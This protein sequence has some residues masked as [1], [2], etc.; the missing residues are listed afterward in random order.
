MKKDRIRKLNKAQAQEG[1]VLYWMDRDRRA[2]HNWALVAAINTAKE[3]EAPLH[4]LYVIPD[5]F[6]NANTRTYDFMLKGLHE[7]AQTLVD[8]NI[9]FHLILGEPAQEIPKF[10]KDNEITT[11]FTDFTPLRLPRKWRDE[12]SKSLQIP[13]YEVD[14]RNIIPCWVTSE[15]EEYAARTIRPKIHKKMD[16]YLD[17]F[18]NLM[19]Y[20]H[21]QKVSKKVFDPEEIIQKL[22]LKQIPK[23]KYYV[24]GESAAKRILHKFLED[25]VKNYDDLRNDPNQDVLSDLSPYL[26]YGQISSQYIVVK[27]REY[28]AMKP[29]Y[30]ESI[31]SFLEELVVR[32][33][34]T[35]NYCY[36][37]PNYDNFAGFKD[38][39]KKTLNEHRADKRDYLYSYEQFEKAETH[40]DLWNAAQIQM[41][42]EGKM[43]GYMRMYW[44][45]KILEWTKSPEEA[46]EIAIKLN[47]TYE[48][49][50]RDPNGY[51]GIAWSIGGIH[52]RAWTEREVYG[53]IRYM[54]YNGAKRKFKV[55][56]YID[57]YSKYEKQELI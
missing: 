54:N 50:G 25:R 13:F 34:L 29:Q 8:R 47:D 57:K 48:L 37:N 43:H 19:T 51:V 28:K 33:E 36:Y 10:I 16:E 3:Y 6:L 55:Q 9:H 5:E 1:P 21:N 26:H 12:L 42:R 4:V 38:W 11:V 49:D 39:A 24:P 18:P 56:D 40:D 31:E 45:K 52:D 15:K 46:Q 22:P 17:D 35:D 14:T 53:K 27:S 30:S 2:H 20:P 23:A 7:T 32:R 41:L 44:C